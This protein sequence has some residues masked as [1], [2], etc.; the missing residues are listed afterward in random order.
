MEPI[1][2]ENNPFF[3]HKQEKKKKMWLVDI[4]QSVVIALFICILVYLFI[5][6][7]NQ[8][9]GPSMQDNFHDKDLVLTNKITQWLGGSD[10]GKSIGLE[11]QRGDVIVFQKPGK[12]DLIKRVIG[13]PGE[14]VM[15]LNGHLF[16]NNKQIKETYLPAT[17]RTN[18]GSYAKEGEIITLKSDEYFVCGDNRGN[19][20]DSRDANYGPVKR[21]WLKGKV[22]LRYWPLDRFGVIG[23]G[24]IEFSDTTV[25][26]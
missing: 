3:E 18:A 9:S 8:V 21:E 23:T 2:Q 25:Q 19:S 14:T 22:I 11:Y 26:Q 10:F 5:A 16:V 13:L 15:V 24:V 12:P 17:L 6:T 1:S 4:L 7:P 20:A